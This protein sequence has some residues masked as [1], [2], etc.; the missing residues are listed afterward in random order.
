[1][2]TFFWIITILGSC[3]GGLFMFG[4]FL[5]SGAPQ[6]A[7]SAALGIGFAVIPYCL[8]RAV[9]EIQSKSSPTAAAPEPPMV[10]SS[11]EKGL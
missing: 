2:R 9:S 4:A 8:A 1:M 11:F 5:E 10:R 7:A 3:I 6:Q